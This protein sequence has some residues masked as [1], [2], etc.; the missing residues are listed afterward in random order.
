VSDEINS[1]ISDIINAINNNE[2]EELSKQITLLISLE[3]ERWYTLLHL[4]N[5]LPDPNHLNFLP[6]AGAVIGALGIAL[7]E[8]AI[9]SK[10]FVNVVLPLFALYKAFKSITERLD[11]L[12]IWDEPIINTIYRMAVFIEDQYTFA[13]SSFEDKSKNAGYFDLMNNE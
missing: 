1:I 5:F 7:K 10:N 8:Q 2:L 12:D 13:R 9:P 4:N 6:K 11:E 3:P